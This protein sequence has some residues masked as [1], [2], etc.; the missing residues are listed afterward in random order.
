MLLPYTPSSNGRSLTIALP[1]AIRRELEVVEE[2]LAARRLEKTALE[3]K[4]EL[5]ALRFEAAM[6]LHEYVC[7]KAG[8]RRDQPRWPVGSGRAG[9]RWSG[10]AGGETPSTGSSTNP[11]SKGHHFVP[12][13]LYN[14]EPLRPETRKVFEDGTTGPLRGQTHGN[15]EAHYKYNQAVIEAFDRFK[16]ENGIA[17]SEDMTPEQAKKFLDEVRASR[18]PWIRGFNMR[19]F[20][21]EFQFYLRRIPRR[22]E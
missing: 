3:I 8:F 2:I 21:Q 16:A 5:A 15:S 7:R 11:K 6:I 12:G 14:K 18:D 9:G 17:R 19:I 20:M 10:G 1:A 22:I 4:Y 13:Q